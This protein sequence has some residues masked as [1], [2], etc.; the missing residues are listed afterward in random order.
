MTPPVGHSQE[1][2]PEEEVGTRLVTDANGV[3]P[4]LLGPH[5]SPDPAQEVKRLWEDRG[6][7]VKSTHECL[8][9]SSGGRPPISEAPKV[10]YPRFELVV[11]KG[12]E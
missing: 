12:H 10:G 11:R 7:V 8:D 3:S 2:L 4:T 5:G 6:R 1:F 9:L